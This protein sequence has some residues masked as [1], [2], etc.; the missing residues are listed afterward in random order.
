MMS[1]YPCG[2]ED[3]EITKEIVVKE[4][5]SLRT[6]LMFLFFSM[7]KGTVDDKGEEEFCEVRESIKDFDDYRAAE[8]EE[9]AVSYIGTKADVNDRTYFGRAV[10]DLRPNTTL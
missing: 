7:S 1:L 6:P 4:M 9:I 3:F 8:K 2:S 5:K 10:Y